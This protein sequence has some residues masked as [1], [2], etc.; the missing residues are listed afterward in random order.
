MKA[1]QLHYTSCRRGRS[2]G[3][4]FQTRSLTPGIVPDEQRE[5]ERRGGYL[6]P[7]DFDP[8]PTPE[9]IAGLFPRALRTYPL[10]SGRLGVTLS[11]YT[12]RDYSGRWGNFFAHTLVLEHAPPGLWPMDLFEWPVWR[13]GLPLEED[14]D[15]PPPDLPE[16]PLDGLPAAE[17]F[18]LE[19]LGTF[20]NESPGRVEQLVRMSRA[21]LASLEDSR[22]L[23]IRDTPTQGLYWLACLQRLLPH[24]MAWG[25]TW[26][27]YQDDPRGCAQV[28]ATVGE[29][30]FSFTEAEARFRFYLF[31]LLCGLESEV[32]SVAEDYP[33]LA[34]GWL[35][36]RPARLGQLFA[37]L[38]RFDLPE[39]AGYLLTACHLLELSE[40]LEGSPLTGARLASMTELAA[41]RALP[42][43]R[44]P[45]LEVLA[46]EVE[47]GCGELSARD[48]LQLLEALAAEPHALETPLGAASQ[49]ILVQM[50]AGPL[51][52]RREG[53]AEIL[54]AWRQLAEA[55]GDRRR[56]LA[57]SFLGAPFWKTLAGQPQ[58]TLQLLWQLTWESFQWSGRKAAWREPQSQALMTALAKASQDLAATT[59][60]ALECLPEDAEALARTTLLLAVAAGSRESPSAATGVGR[61]LGRV[62]GAKPASLA[63]AVRRVLET[64]G[65]DDLLLAEWRELREQAADP[66]E[67]F[68]AYQQQVLP[69]IPH[70]AAR[71]RDALASD[72]LEALPA[73]RRRATAL[74]WLL[75][76]QTG[77]F[78]KG[79]A[80][81][82]LVLGNEALSL[83][84]KKGDKAAAE[85]VAEEATRL[86]RKLVPDRP[87]LR[88]VLAGAGKG[89]SLPPAADLARIGSSVPDL[90]PE[91]YEVFLGAFLGAAL[92]RAG[93]VKEHRQ[94]LLASF[95]PADAGLFTRHYSRFLTLRRQSPWPT[96]AVAALRFWLTFDP[97]SAET[98]PL[99]R[100]QEGAASALAEALAKLDRNGLADLGRQF[101]Q[102]RLDLGATRRWNTLKERA[103]RRRNTWWRRA[104]GWLK[105]RSGPRRSPK[106]SERS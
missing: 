52:Q 60:E 12:G 24:R 35:A 88:T 61:G 7:R 49:R 62:L 36:Q 28:N 22:P 95:R 26:S 29:T 102:A 66:A 79:L 76:G 56:E 96:P 81:R 17:S 93:N 4:G 8:E 105:P 103:E 48:H 63:S 104:L 78:G 87:F 15:E 54:T 1:R 72:V 75:E 101:Q 59:S 86:R 18:R 91:E 67:A 14:R 99:S 45:L 85:R 38:E 55:L 23:V 42:A 73:E 37:F 64:E 13:K 100:L 30:D 40:G 57:G 43:F 16:I 106:K 82:C 25:L 80:E 71:N 33:A 46:R 90:A 84:P 6:P 3:A 74:R 44:V 19:E 89:D 20:L 70:Y 77:G 32:P 39:P 65:A 2:G 41:A 5:I 9:E 31:D 92:H 94:I 68:L 27:T 10:P 83:D 47:A 50:V 98:A 58:A 51:L 53:R 69:A 21:L 34:A 97:T 11:S